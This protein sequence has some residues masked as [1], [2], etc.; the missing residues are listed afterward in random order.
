VKP[1]ISDILINK[2]NADRDIH[3]DS[4]GEGVKRQIWFGLIRLAA[5]RAVSSEAASRK[6]FIWC[7][8][9]PETHLYPAAQRKFFEAMK[10]LAVSSFQI[11]LSTHSTVFTDRTQLQ[12]VHSANLKEGY[13]T[14][15]RCEA[16]DEVFASLQVRNSDFLFFDKFFLVEGDTE[17]VLF[18]H[19]YKLINGR[20]F[21]EDGF[22]LVAM[23][24]KDKRDENIKAVRKV[25]D[26]FRKQE[27]LITVVLD[28]DARHE[29]LSTE[30]L[31]V[32]YVGKQDMED[33]LHPRI[34]MSVLKQVGL[35][36]LTTEKNIQDIINGI[37][38]Q[39]ADRNQK[40]FEALRRTL[41]ITA[42]GDQKA[43]VI[44]NYPKKG[45]NLGQCFRKAIS[46]KEDI[47]QKLQELL[48]AENI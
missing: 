5:E 1:L 48:T 36:Q 43:L 19:L 28:G 6:Q 44:A 24:S 22:Q 29:K 21:V 47:P 2:L 25:F 32:Y 31:K 8:D 33:S 39:K 42:N 11:L 41:M 45:K 26:D 40:L 7:F 16:V 13:T 18:P 38:D 4:Q 14:V 27:Q 12:Y 34:W 9:E 20:E 23:G 37:P 30:G 3:L 35:D 15:G 10:K 46:K 17:V